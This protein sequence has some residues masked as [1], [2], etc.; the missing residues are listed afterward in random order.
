VKKNYI[1]NFLLAVSLVSPSLALSQDGSTSNL[2][3]RTAEPT[4]IASKKNSKTSVTMENIETDVSEALSVIEENYVN[5]KK[6]DY[7]DLF[8]S[9]IDSMLHTLDPHSNYFD[10]KEFDAF[11]TEQR[12]E[13]FGIG[14]TIG[15]L[16]END[17]T[18]T[19]IRATFA[20]SPANRAGLRYGDKIV[21]VNGTSM[22]N[23][24]YYEVRQNL[25][26]PRGTIAKLMVERFG[27][28]E[29]KTV[30][31]VRDAISQP[32]ISEIYMMRPGVGYMAMNGGFNRTTYDE[33]REGL[34][35]LKKQGMEKLILDLRGNRGGLVWQAYQIASTFLGRGQ[36]VFTQRGR[37]PETGGIYPSQNS[38][39]DQTPLVVLVNR[40]SA[41]ASEILAGALQDHD[42]ALIVGEPT[43]GKGLVQQPIPLP[44]G[45][46]LLL[47]IAKYQTPSGRTIQR[48]YS[49]GNLYDYYNQ[50]STRE[51]NKPRTSAGTETRT[52]TGRVVYGGGGIAPDEAVKPAT[53]SPMQQRLQQPIFSFAL[54]L[55]AG[56]IAG[57]ENFKVDRAIDFESDLESK[58]FPASSELFANFKR[59]VQAKPE[60]KIFT[61][62]QL[63]K[64][65]HFIERQL[66]FELATATYGSTTAF[67][68]YNEADPQIMRAIEVFPKAQQ[69]AQ[70]AAN[71]KNTRNNQE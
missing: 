3:A 63:D 66:R 59:Y 25:L 34:S 41:S 44:Y 36:V 49:N 54:S 68:V 19:F 38:S 32:S 58:D 21:E 24:P 50:S 69:L 57:F 46:A 40:Y 47:T 55:A 60:Y 26:G 22:R 8:K 27:T 39:P 64:E 37:A 20:E 31:I 52:D 14:A 11:N 10:A 29:R 28:G 62:A 61:V 16:K 45:S 15:D 56:K 17:T 13:Y 51:P 5:G 1:L 48:D 4:S 2:T 71:L 70:S 67:Q 35:Q 33:F 23:K 42:R 9:S 12:S 6:L 53:L 30:E 65:R 7:N 43:F 18:W